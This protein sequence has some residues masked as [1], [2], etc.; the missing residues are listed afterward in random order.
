[1]LNAHVTWYL[2]SHKYAIVSLRVGTFYPS[3]IPHITTILM[4]GVTFLRQGWV[5]FL[6]I[7]SLKAALTFYAQLPNAPYQFSLKCLCTAKYTFPP[8]FQPLSDSHNNQWL[9][10]PPRPHCCGTH[11]VQP[12]RKIVKKKNNNNFSSPSR[13]ACWGL[14]DGPAEAFKFKFI[15]TTDPLEL[16][17][18]HLESFI[19]GGQHHCSVLI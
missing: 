2:R 12:K 8:C 15:L 19:I 11:C 10:V 9:S 4:K 17:G 6:V 14:S 5:H 16:Q 3:L 18:F 1:M 13:Y 7:H